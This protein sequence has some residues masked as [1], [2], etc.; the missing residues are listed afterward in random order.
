MQ[1]DRLPMADVDVITSP[2]WIRVFFGGQVIA[3]SRQVKLRRGY[4]LRY[5]FPRQ[6]V[7]MDSLQAADGEDL[8]D[9][10]VGDA[11]AK[12]AAFS[13]AED[14]RLADH[15]SFRWQD[16]EAWFEEDERVH[17]HPRD[18]YVRLETLHSSR[19]VRVVVAGEVVAETRRPVLLFE[20]GLPTRYYMPRTDARIE[21][22][23]PSDSHTS[24]PYKGEASY[25]SLKVG[26]AFVEDAV[27]YYPFPDSEVSKIQSL[28]CFYPEKV[29]EFWV[30]GARVKIG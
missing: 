6:D 4:P 19:H 12:R 3:S 28:I 14:Q 1:D 27:W 20:T 13:D 11:V 2:K 24:C 18:P 10:K 8:W 7:N 21:F 17:T 22:L 23:V 29:D 26:D 9:V 16:M 15:I 5:Y 25:F 30:D